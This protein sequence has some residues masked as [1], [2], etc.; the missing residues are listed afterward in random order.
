M[1]PEFTN[2][3]KCTITLSKL[4]CILRELKEISN[5]EQLADIFHESGA[6][7]NIVDAGNNLVS[8]INDLEEYLPELMRK[9]MNL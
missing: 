1:P 9:E 2:A 7:Y 8:A 6:R 5:D 4:D 3:V